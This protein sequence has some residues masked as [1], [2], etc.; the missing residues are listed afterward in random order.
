MGECTVMM[1]KRSMQAES[2][3]CGR[4]FF[5]RMLEGISKTC[6]AVSSYVYNEENHVQRSW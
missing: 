2:Q 1:P 3:T 6:K 4:N 5:K